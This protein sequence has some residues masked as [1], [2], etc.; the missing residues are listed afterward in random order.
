MVLQVST[1]C[2]GSYRP[3]DLAFVLWALGRWGVKPPQAWLDEFYHAFAE[4][5]WAPG[6][7]G[8]A[9]AARRRAGQGRGFHMCEVAAPDLG[10]GYGL[11]EG[12]HQDGGGTGRQAVGRAHARRRM[13]HVEAGGGIPGQFGPNH[14]G[15]MCLPALRAPRPLSPPS[16]P[17]PA[18]FLSAAA[19]GPS[20]GRPREQLLAKV[21]WAVGALG[22][23]PP[24]AVMQHIVVEVQ[25][26]EG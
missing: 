20:V 26:G 10:S 15:M 21:C 7:M 11:G 17:P 22:L 6:R 23:K 4:G 9:T 16:P 2:L 14:A 8:A 25:V 24:P 12:G 13:A 1:G 18:H 5:G 19:S 3:L